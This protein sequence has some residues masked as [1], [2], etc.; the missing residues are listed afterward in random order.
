MIMAPV[1]KAENMMRWKKED[2]HILKLDQ[3]FPGS[4]QRLELPTKTSA[5]IPI[6]SQGVGNSRIHR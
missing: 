2:V 6:D 3:Q 5:Y 4:Q 1:H